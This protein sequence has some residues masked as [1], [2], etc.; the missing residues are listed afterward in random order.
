MLTVRLTE[1]QDAFLD[2]A[3][4]RLGVHRAE[5][6]RQAIDLWAAQQATVPTPPAA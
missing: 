3:A 4:E 5:I 1:A 2:A 6:V